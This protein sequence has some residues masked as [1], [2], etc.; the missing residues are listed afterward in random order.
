MT[1]A[2]LAWLIRE[3]PEQASKLGWLTFQL[4]LLLLPSSAL[5]AGALLFVSFLLGLFGRFA[6]CWRD[7][8]NWPLLLAALL[9]L[10]GCLVSYSGWL[11]WVGLGNWL[12]FFLGFWAFQPYLVSGASRRRCVLWL[13]AGTVPVVITGFGQLWWG[14]QGPWELAG[15]LI[16][17]FMAPGGQPPG[18]LSGLFDYANIAGAWL[19]LIWP[20]ALA[21]VLQ[22]GL[23]QRRRGL[24]LVVAA[25]VVT[26]LVLT[27]S[28]NAWGALMLAVPFVIGPMQWNW[29]LPLF[30]LGLLPVLLAVV[31]GIPSAPQQWARSLLPEGLWTR[32]TD[33]QY[34]QER[35]LQHTRLS[36]WQLALRLVAERPWLGWGAAAF[37]VLYPLYIGKKWHG[38]THNLPLELALSHGLPVALLV[39][40]LVLA[41]LI[42]AVQRGVLLPV[43]G[44]S[45]GAQRTA[46]DEIKVVDQINAAATR[47]GSRSKAGFHSKVVVRS[48]VFDRAW[49]TATLILVVLHGADLPFFDSRLNIAG[50]ILLAGLRCIIRPQVIH[51]CS[52][53]GLDHGEPKVVSD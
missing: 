2:A 19:V 29:L 16:V 24:A 23:S 30:V 42:T 37:S 27:S 31:P 9:M 21:A 36:Q 8:W 26:A 25:A 13:I 28:R 45:A 52:E 6:A 48:T 53:A 35:G 47:A 17:W 1:F 22:P 38:H 15:G 4:G 20:L 49:W 50:W 44:G 18:R 39:V 5:L 11:A 32:I 40:G 41:L 46:A 10:L 34:G 51:P 14:W 12:P 43:A 7:P 33:L 3:C